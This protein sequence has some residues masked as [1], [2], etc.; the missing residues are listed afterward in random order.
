[1]S[2]LSRKVG[3]NAINK[4]LRNVELSK[5]FEKQ[6]FG[7]SVVKN[8]DYIPLIYNY[9]GALHTIPYKL[10]KKSE[11]LEDINSGLT[12][13]ELCIFK[14]LR[15]KLQDCLDEDTDII[16]IEEG[17]MECKSKTCKSK[18]CYIIQAQTRSG[19]EGMTSWVKCSECPNKYKMS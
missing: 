9:I 8:T 1:M 16:S 17:D 3:L 15:Q 4:L 10:R 14:D 5:L 19:D 11:L 2:R 18:R 12:E 13:F 7:L 6:I